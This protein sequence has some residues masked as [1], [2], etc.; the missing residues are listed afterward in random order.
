MV[1][2]LILI[3]FLLD[4]MF[5]LAQ[6][7]SLINA[8]VS[9]EKRLALVIGNGDYPSPNGLGEQPKNDAKDMAA[10]LKELG[11]D[12]DAVLINGSKAQIDK[13]VRLFSANLTQ[14]DVGL[15][16]YAGHGIAIDGV[17]Y[18]I[19][20]DFPEKASK[21]DMQY[22]ATDIDWIQGKMRDAGAENKTNIII[23]D[24]CRDAGNVLR[25]FGIG[26]TGRSYAD[27]GHNWVPP[28]NLPTGVITCFAAS[29]G[30]KADNNAG[31]RN[32][33]YTGT[34]LK[35]IKTPNLLITQVFSRVRADLLK[36]KG[37]EPEEHN[38]LT[39]DFY[40]N[41]KTISPSPTPQ[42]TD[43]KTDPMA[44][45]SSD[46]LKAQKAFEEKNYTEAARIYDKYKEVYRLTNTEMNNIGRMYDEGW[47]YTMS[48]VEAVKWYRKAADN[49]SASGMYNLALMYKGGE[50]VTQDK[51][52]YEAWLRKAAAFDHEDAKKILDTLV[53]P[54]NT[55]IHDIAPVI[56][57][58]VVELLEFKV[59]NKYG[60]IDKTGR[61]VIPFKYDDANS[62]SEGLA[63]V[64]IYGKR[65]FIDKTGREVIPFKYGITFPFSEG[66][67]AV[68]LN[69]KYGYIDK[70][71]REVIPFKY[72][73]ANSF[74]EGL[75]FVRLNDEYGFI[76]KT[77]REVIPFKYDGYY[78]KFSEGLAAVTL[79]DK[80]GYIDKTGREVI[81]FKY[82]Y[83]SEFS[84]GLADVELNGTWGY[85]DKTGRDVI[86]FKYDRAW[87]FSEG[88]AHVQL[89]SKHGY[90]DKTGREVIPFKY[91]W[92]WHFSE[93]LAFAELNGKYGYIDKTGREVIPFIY[94]SANSFSGGKAFV[95][96]N[97]QNFCIDKNGN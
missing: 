84:E 23:V 76:D 56:E 89:N 12:V 40:F 96:L 45:A 69:D 57:N 3:I 51:V 83:A 44:N 50:G 63:D 79:N 54:S 1:K 16:F 19:P 43:T 72:I 87:H 25:S 13:A 59:K 68:K 39:K 20:I 90:I 67:A 81:P 15:V 38:K 31:Q 97:G 64:Q 85:I 86:P 52:Q 60:Y 34:L 74:S 58:E 71:G 77:G 10:A 35:H 75:A 61:E 2:N 27:D 14:Y 53:S 42:T 37:Q 66:L 26:G 18:I 62:F 88:L 55:P 22:S 8:E 95:L 36:L 32:G 6:D 29:N 4:G 28:K 93:G 5:L 41:P 7:R 82:D 21:A 24:A 46:L 30:Q 73:Y 48:D 78:G 47:G 70:T 17:N 9:K 92:A 94:D 80:Y 65:G 11:F 49:G 91:E 33:L